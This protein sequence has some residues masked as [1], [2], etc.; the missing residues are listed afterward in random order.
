ML[1][2]Q[3]RIAGVALESG[4]TLAAGAVVLTTGTFL[5]GTIHIGRE[6]RPA[7]RV[8]DAPAVGLAR[9]LERLRL[10]MGRL[11]TGTPPRLDGRSIAFGPAGG[12]TGGR[13]AGPLLRH[14]RAHNRAADGLPRDRDD[15]G[16][17]CAGA[18][19]SRRDG[20]LC[21][22]DRGQGPALLPLHRGQGGALPGQDRPPHLSGAGGAGRPDSLSERHFDRAAGGRPA[23]HAEDRSR[24]GRRGHAAAGLRHRIRFRGPARAPPDPGAPGRAGPLPRRPD[25]RHHRL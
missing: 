22:A 4:E 16:N 21:R 12:A 15:P 24:P 2:R 9:T 17:A 25:Q 19:P 13:P 1:D 20:G 8:G 5:R 6:T 11:K 14:D 3:G 7:G 10:P 18:R 23:R